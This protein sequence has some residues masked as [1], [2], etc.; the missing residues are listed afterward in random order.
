MVHYAMLQ[1]T[2]Y[3]SWIQVKTHSTMLAINFLRKQTTPPKWLVL[4]KSCELI[5]LRVVRERL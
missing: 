5:V 4:R 3:Y 2:K 1:I